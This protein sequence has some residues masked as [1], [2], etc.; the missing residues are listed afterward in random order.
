MEKYPK[1]LKVLWKFFLL[2]IFNRIHCIFFHFLSTVCYAKKGQYIESIKKS[3]YESDN[4]HASPSNL[5][6]KNATKTGKRI[7]QNV[8]ILYIA[9]STNIFHQKVHEIAS[10]SVPQP[11]ILKHSTDPNRPFVCFEEETKTFLFGLCF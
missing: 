6:P 8:Q 9:P 5:T 1:K 3:F 10:L 2:S 4:S 7:D 11:N